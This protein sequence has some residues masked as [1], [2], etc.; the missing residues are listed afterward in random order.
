[1]SFW[2][3]GE[4]QWAAELAE[5]GAST[6]LHPA[7]LPVLGTVPLFRTFSQ[8]HLRRVAAVAELRRYRPGSQVVRAGGRG[9]AFYII[10]D[11]AAEVATPSGHIHP[12]VAGDFFG[13]LAL[14][15]GA[16]RAATVTAVDSLAT[17]RIPRSAFLKLLK[18]EPSMALELSRGLVALIRD[19]QNEE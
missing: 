13:E 6:S 14:L 9:D 19:M 8:R 15:D 12:L 3:V 10:L 11:G 1:M 7:W 17:G 5:P 18:E 4:A 16:P 2:S